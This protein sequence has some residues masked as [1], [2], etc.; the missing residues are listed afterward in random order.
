[1]VSGVEGSFIIV[2]SFNKF[3]RKNTSDC[4]SDLDLFLDHSYFA[5]F[6]RSR[7]YAIIRFRTSR[8]YNSVK[9]SDNINIVLLQNFSDQ[10][11][12]KVRVR[13]SKCT[14]ETPVAQYGSAGHVSEK[15]WVR[16]PGW[17]FFMLHLY[18]LKFVR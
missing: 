10:K 3:H 1:V 13:P 11:A 12:V 4:H 8:L 16:I 9:R 2:T 14:H 5:P 18:M 7:F 6:Y 17:M 15:V